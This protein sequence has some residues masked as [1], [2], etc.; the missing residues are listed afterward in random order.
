MIAI[1]KQLLAF[2]REFA[3]QRT[4]RI[5]SEIDS[6]RESLDSETKN[7]TGDKHETGRAMIQ[8]EQERL[9]EALQGAGQLE[10]EADRLPE[11]ALH[12]GPVTVGS[13]V[14]VGAFRFYIGIGA[15]AAD[16]DGTRYF[17]ISPASPAG[18]QLLGKQVG[19][20]VVLPAGSFVIGAHY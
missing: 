8:L 10:R 17:C 4:R 5:R 7:S 19:E 11:A 16:L 14:E 13:L 9:M 15:G 1:K 20:T 6:L 2:C 3:H 12:S 18:V